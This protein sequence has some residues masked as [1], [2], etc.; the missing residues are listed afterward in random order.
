MEK[1][2]VR[3]RSKDMIEKSLHSRL[4]KIQNES[5]LNRY[6]R[7]SRVFVVLDNKKKQSPAAVHFV[8]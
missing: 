1:I 3:A 8:N 6:F 4:V 2:C 5:P 7:S